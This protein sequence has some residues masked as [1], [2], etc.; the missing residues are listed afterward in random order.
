MYVS[1]LRCGVQPNVGEAWDRRGPVPSSRFEDDPHVIVRH[2][3]K[4]LSYGVDDRCAAY[5]PRMEFVLPA[6]EAIPAGRLGT[7]RLRDVP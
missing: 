3:E 7:Q 1:S 4:V 2:H 6:D 5:T